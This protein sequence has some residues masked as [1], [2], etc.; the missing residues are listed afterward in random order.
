MNIVRK[1]NNRSIVK[2]KSNESIKP[3][4]DIK[5][6]DFYCRYVISMNQNIRISNLNLIR[7]LFNRVDE[8]QYG[9][10]IDRIDRIKFIKRGLEARIDKKLTNKDMIIQYINGGIMDKPL[11]DTS[12]MEEISDEVLAYLNEQANELV[13][14]YF[15]DERYDEILSLASNLHNANYARRSDVVNQIQQMTADLNMQ[16]NKMDDSISQSQ[17]FTLMPNEFESV[18]SDV[19]ARQN[20]PSRILRTGIT[21]LNMMLDGGFQATRVY[22]LFAQAAGGKSFTMLDLAMQIKKYNKDYIPHD[23]TKI[24]TIVF[25]TMENSEDE[26][27]A[28]M[29]SMVS[30]G[31]TFNDCSL[32]DSINIFR[33][34]GLGYDKDTDPIDLVMIYK[35]NLSVN[36]DYLYTLTDKLRESGREPICFF[37]DHIKR[38]RPVNRRN[39]LRLDLGEVVNEFKAFANATNIPVITDSHLNRDASKVLDDSSSANKKDLIRSLG[40]FNVSESYLMIDNCDLGIIIN[41]ESDSH[42][43]NYMGFKCIKTRT[44]C[45]L[46]LFYQPYLPMNDIKLTEDLYATVPSFKRQLKDDNQLNRTRISKRISHN[47]D[48]DLFGQNVMGSE[49]NSEPGKRVEDV[50]VTYRPVTNILLARNENQDS[51]VVSGRPSTPAI[52]LRDSNPIETTLIMNRGISDWEQHLLDRKIIG[53]NS[54]IIFVDENG[55]VIHDGIL[56]M[57]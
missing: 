30:G 51:F 48:D 40:S 10:D 29:M 6:L 25:L 39:D 14:S 8:N 23:P 53:D 56:A 43:N 42:D 36:T 26:N 15:V 47:D 37:Q 35:P 2:D 19:H 41:K 49:V 27:I 24:P 18:L 32:E 50:G 16:F 13:K 20:S 55:S 5:T 52:P 44:K 4:F 54:A 45:T 28:R 22:I 34:N 1:V 38:I 46:D 31:K 3:L 33:Q 57:R 17:M 11:L 7:D 21:G 12:S 9:S